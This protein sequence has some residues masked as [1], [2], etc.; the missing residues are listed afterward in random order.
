MIFQG[1][2]D[3]ASSYLHELGFEMPLPYLSPVVTLA[4]F[5]KHQ[6]PS[7]WLE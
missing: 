7:L 6:T 4:S 1:H 2:H 5:Y 3:L